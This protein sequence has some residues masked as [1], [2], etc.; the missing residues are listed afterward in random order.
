MAGPAGRPDGRRKCGVRRGHGAAPR[1]AG[2]ERLA[3]RVEPQSGWTHR[4]R[5]GAGAAPVDGGTTAAG[6]GQPGAEPESQ[7]TGSGVAM[8]GDGPRRGDNGGRLSLRLG[9]E[10]PGRGTAP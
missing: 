4:S 8:R 3:V 1:S 9:G 6:C 5:R 10:E 2:T 7:P